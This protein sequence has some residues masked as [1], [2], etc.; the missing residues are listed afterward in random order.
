MRKINFYKR[1]ITKTLSYKLITYFQRKQLK[2]EVMREVDRMVR[3]YITYQSIQD[4]QETII[5]A[6]G[7][8]L[9]AVFSEEPEEEELGDKEPLRRTIGFKQSWQIPNQEENVDSKTNTMD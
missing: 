3:D 7:N 2:R 8:L 6:V 9:Q 4:E 1:E 5:R